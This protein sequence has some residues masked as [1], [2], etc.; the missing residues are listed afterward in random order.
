MWS[1]LVLVLECG[2]DCLP[3][4]LVSIPRFFKVLF[5][6]RHLFLLYN[7]DARLVVTGSVG[8]VVEGVRIRAAFH[9]AGC[10]WT[11]V[12]TLARTR[13]IAILATVFPTVRITAFAGTIFTLAETCDVIR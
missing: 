9:R 10:V 6:I 1:R 7:C 13:C 5:A 8:V 4:I 3:E 12:R 11:T 2:Q